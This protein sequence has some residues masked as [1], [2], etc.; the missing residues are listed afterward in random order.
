MAG[1]S[2]AV[3]LLTLV[4]AELSYRFVE[5]PVRRLGVRQ[6]GRRLRAIRMVV[7]ASRHGGLQL[8]VGWIALGLKTW[9][10][11]E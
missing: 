10:G 8:Q 2:V 3:V 5:Q 11:Q 6:V 7:D 4:C 9:A 1:R